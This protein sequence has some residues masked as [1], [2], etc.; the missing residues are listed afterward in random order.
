MAVVAKRTDFID[1]LS[2]LE[3]WYQ[4]ANGNLLLDSTIKV[5]QECLAMS[6][7]YHIL[8]VGSAAGKDLLLGSP[9]NHKIVASETAGR[10]VTLVCHGDEL[11]LESDSVDALVLHHSLEFAANP[12]QVLREAQ[13]VLTPQGQLLLVGFNPWSLQ[14]ANSRLRGF[15][16]SSFWHKQRFVS[17]AKLTDWLH[18]LGCEV[19]AR[20]WLKP[21]PVT[22]SGRVRRWLSQ[23]NELSEKHNLPVGSI[24][25]V[26]AV[27]Q[28]GS[29]VRD[30]RPASMKRRHLIGLAVPKP[31]T[32]SGASSS[33]T[34]N[35]QGD[36]A[37]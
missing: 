20:R 35:R 30:R 25:V 5:L 13:R 2:E 27:K 9:I 15:S 7:G 1:I 8:Q 18:L 22:G 10:G 33:T 36:D 37:S 29:G 14:G 3:T 26:Q 24:Y 12:H 32:V 17:E 11:P 23:L 21:I 16:R 34:V 19:Q 28:V 6:F 4:G 31:T